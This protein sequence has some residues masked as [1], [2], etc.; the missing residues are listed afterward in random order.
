LKEA[1]YRRAV[2]AGG[3]DGITIVGTDL[4]KVRLEVA[5]AQT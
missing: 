2:E 4:A 1:D 5:K 3:F